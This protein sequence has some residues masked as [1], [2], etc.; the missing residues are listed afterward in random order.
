MGCST[1]YLGDMAT[2]FVLKGA[3]T[4]IGWNSSVT[5]GYVDEATI[6]LIQRLW[7]DN[8]TVEEA[9]AATMDEKGR[10]PVFGAILKYYPTQRGN[11][12]I[13]ELIQ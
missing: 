4:Y 12:T 8:L 9:V 13:D 5:I 1:A 10:D 7:L 6:Y 11:K 2:A 3:S